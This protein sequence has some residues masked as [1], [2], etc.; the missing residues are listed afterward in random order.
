M[1]YFQNTPLFFHFSVRFFQNLILIDKSWSR[2]WNVV[3]HPLPLKQLGVIV[4]VSMGFLTQTL[5]HSEIPSKTLRI[6]L[7][8]VEILKTTGWIQLNTYE[9]NH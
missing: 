8:R 2:E 1:R 9:G 5:T 7:S 3:G 4:R 6:G